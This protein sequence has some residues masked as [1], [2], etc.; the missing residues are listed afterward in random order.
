MH[1]KK[2]TE[3]GDQ[4][5][6]SVKSALQL[7]GD[8]RP[9]IYRPPH[10]DLPEYGKTGGV[11]FMEYTPTQKDETNHSPW[12][13][14]CCSGHTMMTDTRSYN[15]FLLDQQQPKGKRRKGEEPNKAAK[16]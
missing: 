5:F 15:M 12:S 14:E 10:D 6:A 13:L 1:R 2:L 7:I 9:H 11:L 8:R 3:G 4:T 16:L